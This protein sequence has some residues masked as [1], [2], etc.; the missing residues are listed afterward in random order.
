MAAFF[1][2]FSCPLLPS[3]REGRHPHYHPYPPS[4]PYPRLLAS[5]G[6]RVQVPHPVH[7]YNGPNGSDAASMHSEQPSFHT[8]VRFHTSGRFPG[9]YPNPAPAPED[10]YLW[11]GTY[12]SWGP[13]QQ[14]YEPE[15]GAYYQGLPQRRY[16]HNVGSYPQEALSEPDYTRNSSGSCRGKHKGRRTKPRRRS[17]RGFG[18]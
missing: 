7:G 11:S 12:P 13:P 6:S 1:L 16:G 5:A 4:C 10:P 8:D 14:Q 15:V 18:G 2:P 3:E 9:C 17:R